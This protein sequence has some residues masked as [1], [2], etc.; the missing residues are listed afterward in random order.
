MIRGCVQTPHCWLSEK[1]R[2]HLSLEKSIIWDHQSS[3][4]EGVLFEVSLCQLS[5]PTSYVYQV[6]LLRSILLE[7]C[8]KHVCWNKDGYGSLIRWREMESDPLCLNHSSNGLLIKPCWQFA[9]LISPTWMK[10]IDFFFS[11]MSPEKQ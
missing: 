11:F 3:E 8:S 4:T 7:L 6:N 5:P 9:F 2:N 10:T 1:G